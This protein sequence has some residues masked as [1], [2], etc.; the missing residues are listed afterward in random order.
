MTKHFVLPDCQVRP[1]DNFDFLERIGL[2]IVEKQPD[3]I[4][5]LGDF[6]DMASLSSYD[7]GKKSFEGR[8]YINDIEAAKTA[9]TRLLSPIHDYN[10]RQRKNGK[11]QYKPRMILTY[12][13]HC[14]RITRA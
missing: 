1:G 3:V 4:I 2:F 7:Q 5:N 9:M 13:N 6:A 12:G 11:K 8:R 14:D 10:N